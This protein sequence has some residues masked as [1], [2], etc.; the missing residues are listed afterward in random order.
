[1][2]KVI[3]TNS[4]NDPLSEA[5]ATNGLA[6]TGVDVVTYATSNQSAILKTADSKAMYSIGV[7]AD[8]H[9]L[10]PKG[11]L[12]GACLD[13]G[14][15][16]VKVAQSVLDHTW[17][18]GTQVCGMKEGCYRLCAFSNVVPPATIKQARELEEKVK[19]EKVI[20]FKGPLKDREGKERLAAGQKADLMWLA[21]MDFLVNGVEGTLAKK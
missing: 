19:S 12:T 21:N 9:Q 1:V 5:E 3:W 18:P 17:K 6:E 11:W 10:A 2:T 20:I 8:A 7:F 4:W 13:W 15:F 16:Y 14:P